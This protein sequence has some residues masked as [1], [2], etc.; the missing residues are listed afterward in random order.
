MTRDIRVCA[1][2]FLPSN[3]IMLVKSSMVGSTGGGSANGE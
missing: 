3:M 1:S 2:C